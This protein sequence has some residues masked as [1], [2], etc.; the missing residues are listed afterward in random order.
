MKW[1]FS[2][3]LESLTYRSKQSITRHYKYLLWTII[4]DM[5]PVISYALNILIYCSFS[6]LLR[7]QE[8][9]SK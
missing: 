1:I 8:Y 5:S 9:L 6:D 3:Q 7:T 2:D 4:I